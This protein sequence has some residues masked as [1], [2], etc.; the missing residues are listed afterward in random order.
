MPILV[1]GHADLL[2]DRCHSAAQGEPPECAEC[3]GIDTAQ[4][5]MESMTCEDCHEQPGF[6]QPVTD[7][8]L[9]HED[10]GGLHEYPP[11]QGSDCWTC[12]HPHGWDAASRDTCLQC[13]GDRT[14]HM[15][16]AGA[17]SGC[18]EFTS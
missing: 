17:C 10:M 1:G 6:V 2:C 11:H 5:M 12:H 14:D 18:H 13:H 16:D 3:H 9:C 7:C 15:V 4:P 8:A